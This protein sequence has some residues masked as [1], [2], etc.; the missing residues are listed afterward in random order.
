[1]FF[2]VLFLVF[3]C[4]VPLFCSML[5]LGLHTHMLD[6]MSMVMSCLDLQVCMHVLCSYVHVYVRVFTCL[7]AW[8]HVLPCLCARFLHVYMYVPVPMCLDL[9]FH[10]LVH[11][12]LRS[13][14]ALC[15]I[16][17]AC[18][19]NAMFVCLDLCYVCHAM[20]YCS[21]FFVL[22]FFIAFWPSD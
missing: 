2:Y 17:C 6:I 5:M 20:C 12:D 14:H 13:L 19:L 3:L 21:P 16:P 18:V 4:F 22:S 9:C 10:M 8:I 15:Y 11:L 7:Y 1:M